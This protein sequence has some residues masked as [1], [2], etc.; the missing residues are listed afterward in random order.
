[1]YCPD[2]PTTTVPVAV[3]CVIVSP[4]ATLT[5]VGISNIKSALNVF[6]GSTK[7]SAKKIL[8]GTSF[9]SAPSD[10]SPYSP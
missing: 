5:P 6:A 7:S 1:M 2:V 3:S 4:A 8:S 10:T 9:G